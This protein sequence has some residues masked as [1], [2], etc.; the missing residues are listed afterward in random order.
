[1]RN[2]VTRAHEIL[3]AHAAPGDV[4]ID[5]TA[6]NG[7]DTLFLTQLVAPGGKVFAFDIQP[8]ALTN[9][10]RRLE[11]AGV[12]EAAFALI[13]DGHENMARHIPQ[14]WHGRI[15]AVVFNL[16]YLP[17]GDKSVIT[18]A[19]TTLEALRSSLELLRT[20]GGLVVVLYT[21]HAGGV[22]EE[23]AVRRFAGSLPASGKVVAWHRAMATL[24][25]APSVLHICKE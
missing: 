6:G 24:R 8:V 25:P 2:A 3:R 9:A 12:P 4:A 14:T 19:A 11:D 20:G 5:A 21:G 23:E 22:E 16:G 7:H 17:G 10:R 1:M 13:A 15:A 18:T